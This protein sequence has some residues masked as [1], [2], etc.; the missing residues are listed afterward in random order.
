MYKDICGGK[1]R[2]Y[3][4][5][6]V[7]SLISGIFLK[8]DVQKLGYYQVTLFDED[9]KKFRKKVHRLVAECFIPNPDKLPFINHKDG[10]K[11]NNS[12]E[13]LEW[14][15]SY[16]NNLHARTTGLNNISKSNS[17]RWNNPEFRAKAS[18]NMSIAAAVKRDNMNGRVNPNFRYNL[19]YKGE[20]YTI[21][22]L[23]ELFGFDQSKGFRLARRLREGRPC[24]WTGI[25]EYA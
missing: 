7:E 17:D 9:G 19:R 10:D 22:E 16:W 2:V 3:S 18:R 5:G 24:E 11:T 25:V 4:D 1:Y 12:V 23:S 6:R 13:N 8:P 14:C 21:K 15:T 20:I